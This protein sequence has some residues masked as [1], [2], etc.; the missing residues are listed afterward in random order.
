MSEA[1]HSNSNQ[2]LF[3][4]DLRKQ[5]APSHQKLEDNPLSKAI[6]TANV[7]VADYQQYLSALY[8]VTAGCEAT[9]FPAIEGIIWDLKSRYRSQLIVSDL[10]ATGFSELQIAALPVYHFAWSSA[11]DAMGAMYVLEGSTLGGRVLYKHI[12]KTLGFDASNGASYFWGYG[13]QTGSMWKSFISSF[14]QFAMETGQGAEIINSATHT[15]TIIDTWLD[16]AVI[17]SN[18]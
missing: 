10:L 3:V 11:A 6:L 12:H 13:D 5:T 7:S 15:F 4:Q 18:K 17:E 1:R 8:G 2:E 14:T 16:E 9:L